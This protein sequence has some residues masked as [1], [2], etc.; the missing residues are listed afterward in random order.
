MYIHTYIYNIYIFTYI[1]IYMCVYLRN[2]SKAPASFSAPTPQHSKP[3]AAW[4]MKMRSSAHSPR[5]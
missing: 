1:Y 3:Q 4:S 5:I 2:M